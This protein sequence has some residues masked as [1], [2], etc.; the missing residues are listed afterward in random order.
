MRGRSPRRG[1]SAPR[2]RRHTLCVE[3]MRPVSADGLPA[4]GPE[5]R[6]FRWFLAW[7][8]VGALLS[9]GFITIFSIGLLLLLVGGV[10]L[11]RV[12]SRSPRWPE[13]LG[14]IEGVGLMLLVVAFLHRN[15]HL[16]TSNFGSIPA[17]APAGTSISCGGLDPHPW[18]YTGA[19]VCAVATA[20]YV[21]A[22]RYSPSH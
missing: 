9:F 19:I 13:S 8:A 20:A 1:S 17:S 5:R 18:L 15:D 7:A 10:L 4:S 3:P 14:S 21:I 12:L 22:R 11:W 6:G 2:L 16:C